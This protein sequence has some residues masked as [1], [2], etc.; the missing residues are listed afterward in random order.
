[1]GIFEIM[2]T[3]GYALFWDISIQCACIYSVNAAEYSAYTI[4]MFKWQNPNNHHHVY[5]GDFLFAS[6]LGSIS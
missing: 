3:T 4:N 2:D 5:Y 6:F 1:M